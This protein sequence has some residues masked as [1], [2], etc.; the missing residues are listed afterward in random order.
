MLKRKKSVIS[1]R[2]RIIVKRSILAKKRKQ[3]YVYDDKCGMMR[4]IAENETIKKE[5]D[6]KPLYCASPLIVYKT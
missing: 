3:V 6:G 2:R 4:K 5:N 1:M